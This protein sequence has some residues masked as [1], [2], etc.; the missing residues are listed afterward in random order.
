MLSGHENL[1][2]KTARKGAYYRQT[3]SRAR[4]VRTLLRLGGVSDDSIFNDRVA[5]GEAG[6]RRQPGFGSSCGLGAGERRFDA[7]SFYFV[8]G[9]PEPIS[10]QRQRPGA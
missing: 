3:D 1:R 8:L 9:A 10:A 2:A 6:A 5:R 7:A 4:C